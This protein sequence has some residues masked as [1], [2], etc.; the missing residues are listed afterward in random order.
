MK[1][2]AGSL[3]LIWM[4]LPLAVSTAAEMTLITEELAP[5][6]YTE[7]GDITG[8]TTQVVREIARR[9]GIDDGITVMPWARGYQQLCNKP[10]VVLF[11]TARTQEREKLFHWVGPLYV[12][13]MVFYARKDDQRRIDSL[14]AAR[15]VGAIGTYKNDYGEEVLKSLGFTNL[16]RSNSPRSNLRKLISGRLDLWFCDS[17]SAHLVAR[18]AGVAPGE[19][20]AVFV[21]EQV[22]SYIAISKQTAPAIVQQWQAALDAMKTDGTF[23]WLSRKWLPADA[24][25]VSERQTPSDPL[26]PVKIY[27]EN[28]PPSAYVEKGTLKGL[29]VEIVQE[30][31]RRIGQPDTITVVPWA[32]GYKMAL[33]E[34]NVALFATTRLPQREALFSWVGPLYRQRWGFYR[35]KGS[36]VRVPDMEAA[37]K[38]GRIGTYHQDA[39]MQ[40]LEA[41]GFD[42]LVPTNKNLTNIMHLQR[43]NIDL[44]VSSD[45]NLAH[46]ARQAGVSPDRLE[47]AYA[48][49]SVHNYIAFSKLTSPHVVRLWQAVLGEM[50]SDGSYQRICQKYNYAPQ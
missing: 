31:L 16:D 50:K 11:T 39:K 7:N 46:L 3:L 20:K 10:N 32:R 34:A 18:E 23:W 21:Y 48:F 1:R 29:S 25:E 40:Y 45:F 6:N 44:W 28:Y 42:N 5:F 9:L 35:W 2:I 19:I 13:K 17:A 26:F 36:D 14:D 8:A 49:H 27:T 38:V 43:G 33:S 12:N 37:R 4:I 41:Q 24:I 22:H 15:R 30:I 47:L